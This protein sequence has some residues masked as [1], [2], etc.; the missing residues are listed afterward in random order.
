MTFEDLNF[1]PHP[2]DDGVQALVFFP[3]GY[4]ASVIRTGFSYGGREGKYELAVLRGTEE[5]WDLCYD[6]PITS[7]V[8]GYLTPIDITATLKLIEELK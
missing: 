1:Q 7:D 6:T 3:N 4:G 5:D 2:G 8:L